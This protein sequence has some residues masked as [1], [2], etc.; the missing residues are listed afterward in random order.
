MTALLSRHD[1]A[2]FLQQRVD[3]LCANAF[4]VKFVFAFSPFLLFHGRSRS[5]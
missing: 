2:F 3:F 5:N 4:F 1:G